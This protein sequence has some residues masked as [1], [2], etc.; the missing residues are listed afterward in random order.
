[1]RLPLCLLLLALVGTSALAAPPETIRVRLFENL[2]P[3]TVTL[4]ATTALAVFTS[5]DPEAL[6]LLAPGQTVTLRAEALRIRIDAPG[7]TFYA[8]AVLIGQPGD[9]S[10][11][12][13]MRLRVEAGG[14]TTEQSYLGTLRADRAGE[15]LQLVHTV[16][17]E[18]YVAGV[19]QREYG[20]DDDEGTKAMAVL[21]RTY[22]LYTRG[23]LHAD[24]D[25]V[26]H[27][28]SQV[29]HGTD[30]VTERVKAAVAATRGQVLMWQGNL[31]EAVYSASNGGVAASNQEVWSGP[32]KPY[33][34]TRP[35]PY[36]RVSP[37]RVWTTRLDRA[38]VL[39][40]LSDAYGRG[41]T[42]FVV[43][44]RTPEGRVATVTLQRAGR[45]VTIT[46]PQFRKTLSDRFGVTSIRST[47]FDARREGNRYVFEGRGFGHGVGMSQW[48]AHGQALEGRTAEQILAFYY[49]GTDISTLEGASVPDLPAL[50]ANDD[51]PVFNDP[52]DPPPADPIVETSDRAAELLPDAAP[53][54]REPIAEAMPRTR[55]VARPT[56][57]SPT[58][59]APA[60]EAAPSDDEER[61]LG[62]TDPEPRKKPTTTRRR[63]W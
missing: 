6:V 40:A 11:A 27:V 17:L 35:D 23:R 25:V 26:D 4:E 7:L 34:Q 20:L 24:Y 16:D 19:V 60:T 3:R 31:A 37:H 18:T 46:G 53:I 10:G 39:R 21:A 9:A 50:A 30:G 36:D 8:P 61:P 32:A 33:L 1:M 5:E 63:G 47:L 52:N 38:Q 41:V 62:W 48:G 59:P 54:V 58:V 22:A 56:P 45:D 43:A 12:V 49:P 13:G 29:Y 15:V 42:G 14:K 44:G 51:T 28:G 55:P 57:A 2:S